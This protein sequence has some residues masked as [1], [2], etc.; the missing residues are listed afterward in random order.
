MS[1]LLKN[2]GKK[3]GSAWILKD[4]NLHI[5][6]GECLALL[7]PSG[8]GKSSTLRLIAGLDKLD[9]GQIYLDGNEITN[10]SRL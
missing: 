9:R 4:I 8:C 5:D 2:L 6:D 10:R 3:V 1:L 7:G